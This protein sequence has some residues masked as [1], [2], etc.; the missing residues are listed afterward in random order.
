LAV[1]F[2]FQ[3]LDR[4]ETERG[5]IDAIAQSIWTRPIVK[6]MAEMG[7]AFRAANFG[8]RLFQLGVAERRS[9]SASNAA[10]SLE[11]QS[12][13][14]HEQIGKCHHG[15][16]KELCCCLMIF[17]SEATSIELDCRAE[18]KYGNRGGQYAGTLPK[19]SQSRCR[20]YDSGN[21]MF[22]NGG[23]YSELL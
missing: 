21:A 22:R 23:L 18:W 8:A 6:D 20:T 4:Y 19:L 12:R 13:A 16:T 15:A 2:F 17:S 3:F 10:F 7:I 9:S 5:G 11:T 14:E 1:A